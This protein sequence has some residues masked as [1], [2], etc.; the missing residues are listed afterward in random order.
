MRILIQ[1]LNYSPE[2]TGVGKYT[3]EMAEWLASQGHQVRVVTAP[4]HYPQYRVFEGYFHNRFT[5]E[6]HG[7]ASSAASIVE[8][9]RCPIWIPREPRDRKSTRLNSSHANISYAVFCL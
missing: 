5:R 4:P 6:K 2:P 8:V 7:A 1:S 9:F 3:G